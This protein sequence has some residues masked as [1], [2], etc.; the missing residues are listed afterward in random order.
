MS[1]AELFYE[2]IEMRSS[3]S[4]S[5]RTSVRNASNRIF[6]LDTA[7]K[8]TSFLERNASISTASHHGPSFHW[9]ELH[10]TLLLADAA[11]QKGLDYLPTFT[12]ASVPLNNVTYP[13]GFDYKGVKIPLFSDADKHRAVFGTPPVSEES[14]RISLEHMKNVDIFQ[15]LSAWS[16]NIPDAGQLF[17]E[18]MRS[19]INAKSHVSYISFC[20]RLV[21]ALPVEESKKIIAMA[22]INGEAPPPRPFSQEPAASFSQFPA[23]AP[24]VLSYCDQISIFNSEIYTT[25]CRAAGIA[26]CVVPLAVET[27]IADTLIQELEHGCPYLTDQL[28]GRSKHDGSLDTLAHSIGSQ[29]YG[30][31]LFWGLG[32]K[33]EMEKLTRIGNEMV[34]ATCRVALEPDAIL[35][36]LANETILPAMALSFA[37]MI[38][39]GVD[40]LGGFSQIEY[41]PRFKRA[42]KNALGNHWNP[43]IGSH[44]SRLIDGPVVLTERSFDG[45]KPLSFSTLARVPSIGLEF[46]VPTSR[47]LRLADSIAL[48]Y[49]WMH[50]DKS[51]FDSVAARQP[52]SINPV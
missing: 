50:N 22:F 17:I 46:F 37:C 32:P 36:A 6:G 18:K 20:N 2:N 26:V 21:D 1:V 31:Y 51:F 45:Y 7:N 15:Y 8:I 38:F 28:F 34:G 19:Q 5:F 44:T 47:A 23:R 12:F 4:D 52:I 30:T 43:G 13:R 40:A 49:S 11:S 16:R 10:S 41:L 33:G 24:T 9:S 48:G 35:A 27:I 25:L 29:S 39:H 42:L 3:I 14:L